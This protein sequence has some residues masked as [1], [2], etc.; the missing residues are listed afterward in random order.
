MRSASF[1]FSNGTMGEATKRFDHLHT[2]LRSSYKSVHS[3]IVLQTIISASFIFSLC[4]NVSN[5]PP[6]F[7]PIHTSGIQGNKL[8]SPFET[9]NFVQYFTHS[10][11]LFHWLNVQARK[12]HKY[13]V[14]MYSHLQQESWTLRCL[15]L[16]PLDY[17]DTLASEANPRPIRKYTTI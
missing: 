12:R 15:K 5:N 14:C 4:L 10:K 13:A 8:H 7:S 16:R 1:A 17:H 9:I 3:F 6:A 11:Y 2:N